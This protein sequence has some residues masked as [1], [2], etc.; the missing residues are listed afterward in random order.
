MSVRKMRHKS[1]TVVEVNVPKERVVSNP[2][3]EIS[4]SFTRHTDDPYFV[5]NFLWLQQETIKL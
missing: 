2:C 3:Q 1:G 4:P 5:F